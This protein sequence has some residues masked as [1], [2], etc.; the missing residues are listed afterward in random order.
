MKIAMTG[1]SGF[2]GQQLVPVL[3][4]QG[5]ETLLVG[6]DVERLRQAFANEKVCTYSELRKEAA[7]FDVLL[8]LAVVNNDANVPDEVFFDV[9]VRQMLDVVS[10]AK[11]AGI[12]HFVLV[13][14]THALDGGN[15]GQYAASKRA[16]AQ[17][18]AEVD[19]IATSIVYLPSVYANQW[20]GQLQKLNRLPAPLARL[21][22]RFL[23]AIKPTVHV[24]RLADFVLSN[25]HARVEDEVILSDGQGSNLIY[26]SVRRLID[27][28]FALT[29]LVCFWWLLIAIWAAI[30]LQSPGPGLFAQK[31]VGRH[32]K[33]FICYKFR[34]MNLGTVERGTH[35]VS[36]NAVTKIGGILRRTKLDELPQIFNIL[37][38][39]ISLVG[40]RPCLPVQ[41]ELIEARRR[42]DVLKLKPGITGLSQVNGIDMSEPKTL[43]RWD[44]RYAALQSLMLD[45]RIILSTA[46]G[47][48]QGD[49][50]L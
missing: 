28:G 13:S 49:R 16:A 38:N 46:I 6:R 2:V 39:E 17:R 9:N 36:S 41:T 26:R 11:Q 1:A 25:S 29:M 32:G 7:G 31:R 47:R 37:K 34:T 3:K 50:V 10:V 30:R 20:S 44:S 12:G 5:A 24:S 21:L 22:F 40:P 14:S 15:V 35:E 27:L 23:A 19:G 48:G 33:V 8:H 18:L 4:A 45:L 43:A 42:R